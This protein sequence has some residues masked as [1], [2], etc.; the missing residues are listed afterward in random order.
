ML[1][2]SVQ[3]LDFHLRHNQINAIYYYYYKKLR[4]RWS[5]VK[6]VTQ[7]I[8]IFLTISL[9]ALT[10]V[11]SSGVLVI[12][13]VATALTGTGVFATSLVTMLD[14]SLITKK[15]KSLK[16]KHLHIKEVYDKLHYY[17][18]RV[19]DDNVITRLREKRLRILSF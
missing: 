12:P 15:R 14:K 10:I 16:T 4:K 18:Q 1:L 6:N 7:G 11:I 9:G 13:V 2:V 17:F 3:P 19:C 8:G 5:N